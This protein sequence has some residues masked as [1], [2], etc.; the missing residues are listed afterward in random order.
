MKPSGKKSLSEIGE[1]GEEQ[2]KAFLIRKG[3][4]IILANFKIP[5]GRTRKGAS[6]TGE[7]DLIAEKDSTICFIE[8]KTRQTVTKL[9]AVSAVDL[10][11]QR[12]ITRTAKAYL[13]QFQI[14]MLTRFDVIGIVPNPN[15]PPTIL[16]MKG[17]WSESKFRKKHWK[18]GYTYDF[19]F[20]HKH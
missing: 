1:F 5:I 11:K 8:V 13:E 20:R 7:I 14:N 16:H 2:A 18:S 17:F 12:Q 15:K 6:L 9:R 19:Q 3:Y 4:K 10:R